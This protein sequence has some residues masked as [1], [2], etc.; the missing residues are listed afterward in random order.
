MSGDVDVTRDG[1]SWICEFSEP[2]GRVR[3]CLEATNGGV[4]RVA[5]VSIRSDAR[6]GVTAAY[7]R[8]APHAQWIQRAKD[9]VSRQTPRH[10]LKR[11]S[12][13]LVAPFLEDRRGK[14]ARDDRDYAQLAELYVGSGS[15]NRQLARDLATRYGGAV[16]SWRNHLT[17]ARRFVEVR[18]EWDWDDEPVK[19]FQLTDDALRLL[20]GDD[21]V[22]RFEWERDQDVAERDL[23][24]RRRQA[25][26]FVRRHTQPVTEW[27]R[28]RAA[29]ER[30]T[31]G[32]AWVE[33]GMRAAEVVLGST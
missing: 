25:S 10:R 26:A 33:R 16:Q 1:D 11:M 19:V 32:P 7:L 3:I 2:L 31:R 27:E 13:L 6:S 4:F 30:M 5:E 8:R 29:Y 9:A 24:E 28:Q 22:E 20:Y 12:D 15:P 23:V 17:K 21:Y 14:A 18:E